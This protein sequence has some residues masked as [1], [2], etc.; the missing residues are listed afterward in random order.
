MPRLD[1]DPA[2]DYM[3]DYESDAYQGMR[4]LISNA[5]NCSVL[6]AITFLQETWTADITAKKAQWAAQEVADAADRQ[7]EEDN[8]R[9]EEA[10]QLR[11]AG[12]APQAIDPAPKKPTMPSFDPDKAMPNKL[13]AR[14]GK[15]ALKRLAEF[16]YVE[17]WYF[18]ADGCADAKANHSNAD[19][20][21]SL[22]QVGGQVSIRSANASNASKKAVRDED[23]TWAEMTKAKN[24]F[25]NYIQKLWPQE[26]ANSHA[27]FFYDI[28]TSDLREEHLG[29]ETLIAYQ[30]CTRLEWHD[31]L[32][33]GEG[34]DIA[35][36]SATLLTRIGD[37][38]RK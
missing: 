38:L 3:P 16:K 28:E 8:R 5:R 11:E 9:K 31:L 21:Y 37:E 24:L 2:T 19:D 7:A 26:H 25:L 33:A 4:L 10:R 32:A 20:T 6:D 34:F 35:K 15:Y 36:G 22:A 13:L 30:A 12:P 18:T 27:V 17:L 29:E 1:H 23:L 14:P